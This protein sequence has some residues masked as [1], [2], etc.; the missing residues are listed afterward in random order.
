MADPPAGMGE[1][2]VVGGTPTSELVTGTYVMHIFHFLGS[3]YLGLNDKPRP[4]TL[5]SKG[6]FLSTHEKQKSQN[7]SYKV[8]LFKRLKSNL[9]THLRENMY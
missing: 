3:W 7:I 1:L 9:K 2:L 4:T 8:S 6:L 5:Q